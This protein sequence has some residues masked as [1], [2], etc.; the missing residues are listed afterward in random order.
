M[1]S[2]MYALTNTEAK[3]SSAPARSGLL[4]RRCVCGGL[5]GVDGECPACRQ[6]RLQR[7][8]DRRAE[9]AG[10]PPIVHDVL[11]SPGEPL[12]PAMRAFLS[13]ASATTSAR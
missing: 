13:L 7:Q 3:P 5:P 9:P 8:P 11:R 12:D 4:Q 2:R 10:V 6:K 1:K